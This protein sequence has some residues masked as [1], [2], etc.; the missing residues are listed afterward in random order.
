MT[1]VGFEPTTFAILYCWLSNVSIGWVVFIFTL[2]DLRTLAVA[3]C[4]NRWSLSL[5]LQLKT[6]EGVNI[7]QLY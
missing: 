3:S 1:R 4:Q 5:I 7:T 2:Q 6:S